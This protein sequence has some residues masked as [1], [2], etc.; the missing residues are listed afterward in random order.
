MM[1]NQYQSV[2]YCQP[3]SKTQKNY[4]AMYKSTS[5]MAL[6]D[7]KIQPVS[8]FQFSEDFADLRIGDTWLGFMDPYQKTYTETRLM[9]S[10]GYM[11][12]R[13]LYLY[14]PKSEGDSRK[15]NITVGFSN[16]FLVAL[17]VED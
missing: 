4:L 13:P 1:M 3:N 14:A 6:Q 17:I 2:F 12:Q 10:G 11:Q 5:F 15:L 8:H 7:K 9:T 16:D